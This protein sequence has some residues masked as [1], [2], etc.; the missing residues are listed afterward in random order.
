MS[1]SQPLQHS[2]SDIC[3]DLSQSRPFSHI[4]VNTMMTIKSGSLDV[5]VIREGKGLSAQPARS[6]G[7][8]NVSS[9]MTGVSEALQAI[10]AR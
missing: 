2:R 7:E 8:L 10:E 6:V 1:S 5:E 9:S 4:A 3:S